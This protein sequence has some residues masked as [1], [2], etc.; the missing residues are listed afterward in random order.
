MVDK[1]FIFAYPVACIV[2]RYLISSFIYVKL[3]MN[4]RYGEIMTEYLTNCIC[5]V[6]LSVEVFSILFIYG[7]LKSI[8]VVLLADTVVLLGILMTSL[9]KK[10]APAI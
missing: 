7:V 8:G 10:G 6:V 9:R 5:F 3:Q 4:N 2:I 1:K